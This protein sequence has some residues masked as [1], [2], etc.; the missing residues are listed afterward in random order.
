MTLIELCAYTHRQTVMH[1]NM[2]GSTNCSVSDMSENEDG[3]ETLH[4]LLC[5]F[6]RKL[7]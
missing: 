6:I 4:F 2:K 1:V 7:L 5:L 3:L